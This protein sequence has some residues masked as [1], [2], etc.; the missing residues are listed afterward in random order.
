MLQ[1]VRQIVWLKQIVDGDNLDVRE[2]LYRCPE[3]HTA[4]SAESIDTH[5][6]CHI[7]TPRIKKIR[8]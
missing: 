4:Y 1:H 7:K 2:I 5:S 8:G 3:H 6:Y